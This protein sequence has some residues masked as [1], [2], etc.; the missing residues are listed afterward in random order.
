MR[1]PTIHHNGTPREQLIDQVETA[2]CAMTDAITALERMAPNG[3]DYYPQGPEAIT[4]AVAEHRARLSKARDLV[5]E[6]YAFFN[7]IDPA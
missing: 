3:R 2:V 1:I 6:L 4:E 5:K 7:A